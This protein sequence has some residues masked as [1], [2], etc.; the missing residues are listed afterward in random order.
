MM[1]KKVAAGHGNQAHDSAAQ[2]NPQNN[3][4]NHCYNRT[5]DTNGYRRTQEDANGYRPNT[6]QIDDARWLVSFAFLAVAYVLT[7][8][9][10]GV[11]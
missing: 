3:R 11:L 4:A 9:V 10:S 5:L 1:I 6:A 8:V 2:T 7:L